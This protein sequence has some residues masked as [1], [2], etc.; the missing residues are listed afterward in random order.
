[1][2]AMTNRHKHIAK[3]LLDNGASQ[4][5]KTSSGRTAAD[6]LAPDS[7]MSSYLH[8]NGYN[9]GSAGV[10]ED[11][12]YQPG[13]GQDRFEEELENELRR[14]MMM[15]SARDLEVDLGNVGIDDQPEVCFAGSPFRR[16]G[17][18]DYIRSWTNLKSSKNL[19]GQGACTIKCLCSRRVTW[20]ASWISLSPI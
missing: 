7:D 13:F 20:T 5:A 18:A 15:E 8:S 17:F 4:D 14:R 2:W 1:M 11:D 12:F 3:L 19:T 6:F 10:G 16:V 9:I